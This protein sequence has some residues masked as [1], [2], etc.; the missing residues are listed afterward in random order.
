MGDIKR[1]AASD[2][3]ALKDRDHFVFS[4]VALV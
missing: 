3:C 2:F 4:G 1:N